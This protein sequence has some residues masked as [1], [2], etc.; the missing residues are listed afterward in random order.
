MTARNRLLHLLTTF[1]FFI[2]DISAICSVFRQLSTDLPKFFLFFHRKIAVIPRASSNAS[3]LQ[4][5][6]PPCSVRE[7]AHTRTIHAA[8]PVVSPRRIFSQTGKTTLFFLPIFSKKQLLMQMPYPA[9]VPIHTPAPISGIS[10]LC[11]QR[12]KSQPGIRQAIASPLFSLLFT[13]RHNHHKFHKN[14]TD[15]SI[16]IRPVSFFCNILPKGP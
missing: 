10:I 8:L 3:F 11:P 6:I 13:A 16:S 1:C 7:T 2:P 12:N 9:S 4:S 15:S 5:P 14:R